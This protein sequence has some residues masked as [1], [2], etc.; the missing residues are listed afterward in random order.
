M[1][2]LLVSPHFPE[3][4]ARSV[5]GA[6]QRLRMWLD[7]IQASGARLEVLF[8]PESHVPDGPEDAARAAQRIAEEWGIHCSVVLCAREPGQARNRVA[9]ALLP[10]LDAAR[11]PRT[12]GFAGPRQREALRQCLARSPEVVFFDRL[13]PTIPAR[14][15]SLGQARVVLDLGDV[16]HRTFLRE[17]RQ[18]P[19]RPWKPVRYLWT[20]AL[21]WSERAAIARSESTFVCSGADQRYLERTMGVH[22]VEVIPNAVACVREHS[23]T[24]EPNVL[25]LGTYGYRPNLVAA[26]RLI[27]EVRPRL[28]QLV[29]RARILIA[30]PRP[31]LLPSFRER[32]VGVEFLGFVPDLAAL[33]ARARVLCCPI[34]SGG[35]TR[36]KILEAAGRGVPVVST[37]IGAEGIELEP[38]R[39]IVL[40]KG[41]SALAR[42]CAELLTD[43][44]RAHAIGARAQERVRT[45][46]GRAAVV[47]RMRGIVGSRP[48]ERM[49]AGDLPA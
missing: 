27:R 24:A 36:I 1:R 47:S 34:Q 9:R 46:Y 11:N 38:E 35:G 26:E 42:A 25:Y 43:D 13:P 7:A 4:F 8:Y 23:L 31:E 49:M 29:P 33:Y 22:N 15:L 10:A 19:W 17:V 6:Y 30:G 18:P 28:L 21:W 3:N 39:E 44:E 2:V 45:L 41:A 32:P 14:S 12:A 37:P 48:I 5:S 20:P 16:E 40:R